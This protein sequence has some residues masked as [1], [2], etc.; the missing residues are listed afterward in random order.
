[1]SRALVRMNRNES[2]N[3]PKMIRTLVRTAA[4]PPSVPRWSATAGSMVTALIFS[5]QRPVSKCPL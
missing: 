5:W 3:D 2:R 1:M 4:P